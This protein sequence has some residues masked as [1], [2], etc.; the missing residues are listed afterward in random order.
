MITSVSVKRYFKTAKENKMKIAS[1][2]LSVLTLS[3]I[4]T[5]ASFAS[6]GKK[7][8]MGYQ[9]MPMEM[10]KEQRQEMATHHEKMALCLRSD[11]TM[12]DCHKEMRA[13]CDEKMGMGG[14]PMMGEM[15]GMEPKSDKASKKTE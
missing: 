5:S 4:V 13:A 9:K 8:K 1:A 15:R 11:R 10:T 6:E 12:A 14:C 2:L 7:S 3:L